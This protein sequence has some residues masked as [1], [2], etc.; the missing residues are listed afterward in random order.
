MPHPISEE[1]VALDSEANR[2][3]S[4]KLNGRVK[5]HPEK[6]RRERLICAATNMTSTSSATADFDKH[7]P[8][9]QQ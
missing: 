3:L 8:K 5:R 2:T 1:T 6:L 7:K 4:S 9:P